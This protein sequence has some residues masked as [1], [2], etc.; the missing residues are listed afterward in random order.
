LIL[1]ALGSNVSGPWGNPR[2]TVNKAFSRLGEGPCRVLKTSSLFQTKPFG[3]TRQP[4]FI[5][6]VAEITTNLPPQNLM[7]HLHEIELSADRRRTIRWGPR[8][9]DLDLLDYHGR[10][11]KGK[12]RGAGHCLP[13]KLPHPGIAE[14]EFVLK[15]LAEIANDWRHPVTGLG[16]S[17]MLAAL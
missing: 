8:T 15:P 1:I 9:L 12:G 16:P 10:I 11:L 7:A 14:R 13:L 4:D 2:Q 5:N 17:Q 6:A 3:V